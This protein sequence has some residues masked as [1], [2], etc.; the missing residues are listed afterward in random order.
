MFTLL[1]R[2]HIAVDIEHNAVRNVTP[3]LI[4]VQISFTALPRVTDFIGHIFTGNC[5]LFSVCLLE[6]DS[7]VTLL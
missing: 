4:I 5:E 2:S 3:Y 1:P 6:Y 7:L